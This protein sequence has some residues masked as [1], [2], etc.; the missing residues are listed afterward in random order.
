MP[1]KPA[2]K[3]NKKGGRKKY[4][5]QEVPEDEGRR[6]ALQK[7][8]DAASRWDSW[9]KDNLAISIWVSKRKKVIQNTHWFFT[10]LSRSP[11]TN[12]KFWGPILRITLAGPFVRWALG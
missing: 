9:I 10:Y 11:N 4:L 6:D 3:K 12:C 1:R 8:Y 7:I 2:E 5:D